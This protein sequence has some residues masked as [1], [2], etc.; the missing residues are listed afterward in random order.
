MLETLPSKARPAKIE[1]TLVPIANAV[2]ANA[3]PAWRA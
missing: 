2:A 1:T 3:R